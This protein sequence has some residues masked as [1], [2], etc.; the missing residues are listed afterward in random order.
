MLRTIL[1]GTPNMKQEKNTVEKAAPQQAIQFAR[2]LNFNL[3]NAFKCVWRHKAY[4]GRTDL[5]KA[6]W[7][8]EQQI[9]DESKFKKLKVKK[10]HEIYD[11]LCLVDFD[12]STHVALDAVL[13]VGTECTK[14]NIQWAVDCVRDLLKRMTSETQ[15]AKLTHK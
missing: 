3:G 7:Y 12:M 4:G 8:L 11:Q 15:P 1:T 14:D 6:L 13:R 9:E 5:E 2:H 10:Y